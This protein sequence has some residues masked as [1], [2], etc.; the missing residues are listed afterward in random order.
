MSTPTSKAHTLLATLRDQLA[1]VAGVQTAKI[2]LETGI[3]PDDYPLVRLVPT[4]LAPDKV[5]SR[6]K[7]EVLIYFGQPFD[8][9]D[10]GGLEAVYAQWLAMEESLIAA[11]YQCPGLTCLYEDTITDEDRVA[12]YKLLALRVTVRG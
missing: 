5:F 4:R 2:G 1:G 12:G 6:R 7:L 11:C 10:A 8:E 9:S 3:T